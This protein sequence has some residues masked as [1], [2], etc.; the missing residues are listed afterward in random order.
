M[1]HIY[2]SGPMSGLPDYNYPLFNNAANWLRLE[3]YTVF[4]PAEAFNGDQTRSWSDYMRHDIRQ[5][6]GADEVRVLPDWH[7]STGATLEVALAHSIGIPV[8]YMNGWNLWGIE[9]KEPRE[10]V[11]ATLLIHAQQALL[12]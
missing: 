6:L 12:Q 4:N 2:L 3:G 7:L 9:H 10:G 5:I 8:R 1:T 11:K